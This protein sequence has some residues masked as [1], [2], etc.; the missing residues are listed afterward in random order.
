MQIYMT[1]SRFGSEDTHTMKMYHK[2][3]HY[4]MAD[5]LA[6]HF[7]CEGY[8]VESKYAPMGDV[9]AALFEALKPADSGKQIEALNSLGDGI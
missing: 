9:A 3:K 7:I 8:A 2:G 1:S 5:T 4:D 6:R